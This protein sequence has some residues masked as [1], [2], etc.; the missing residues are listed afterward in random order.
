MMSTAAIFAHHD[1]IACA[2]YGSVLILAEPLSVQRMPDGNC[3]QM[4][5]GEWLRVKFNGG[6]LWCEAAIDGRAQTVVVNDEDFGAL[7]PKP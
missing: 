3:V 2:P 4:Q 7:E 5:A 6:G 1:K